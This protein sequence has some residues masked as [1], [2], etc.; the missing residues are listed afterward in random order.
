MCVAL[1]VELSSLDLHLIDVP[2]L[3]LDN[4]AQLQKLATTVARERPAFVILDPL[5]DLHSRDENDAQAVAALLRPLREL[6]RVY[7][8]AVLLVHHMSKVTEKPRR[9]GQRM[10][11]S[12]V[13]HGWLDSALYVDRLK[14]GDMRVT[15]EHRGAQPPE[16]FVLRLA[17]ATDDERGESLWFERVDEADSHLADDDDSAI[18]SCTRFAGAP[19][20]R[21]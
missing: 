13:L 4:P 7:G 10:R 6:Q 17:G 1:D 11:G 16:P 9:A 19:L 3:R 5:R 12:S 14:N 18:K 20:T 2:A 15:V 21:R 8:C